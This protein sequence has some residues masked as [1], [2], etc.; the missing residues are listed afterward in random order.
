M[1]IEIHLLQ[2]VAPSCLNRDDTNTPKTCEFGGFI[3]A[4]V[5]SQSWKRAVREFFRAENSVPVG[6]RT[7]D[8]AGRLIERLG[9]E[10][11]PE[12]IEKF[13]IEAYSKMDGKAAKGQTAAQTAVLVFIS[14]AEIEEAAACLRA[15]LSARD[16]APRLRAARQSA[17][18]ALFG[19]MLAENP[20]RNV[21]AACQV[22]HALSTHAVDL[23]TD[24]FTAVDDL[25][26]GRDESGAGMLGTQGFNSACFYRYALIDRDQLIQN[27]S[28]DAA[29]ADRTIAA[30]LNAF[31]LALPTAKQNSH[32][33]Q[34]PPSFGLFVVREK[35]VPVSL[36]NAFANPVRTTSE[37]ADLIGSS[38]YCLSRYQAQM[39]RVYG[40]YEGATLAVFHDREDAKALGELK[41]DYDGSLA[42]A[43]ATVMGRIQGTGGAAGE[44]AA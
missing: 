4:R 21:D 35:G 27:L 5:S 1:K 30:F 8:L 43:I 9:A 44:A 20:E 18:I 29:L 36:A 38:I 31:T 2:N 3:R 33:A 13:V 41:P 28:G 32:A 25:T 10:V 7:K 15:G 23:E 17:D 40:L 24:F 26:A 6:T 22:A 37:H 19:R 16:A 42:G 12:V 11:S 34:N 14:D 39:Q